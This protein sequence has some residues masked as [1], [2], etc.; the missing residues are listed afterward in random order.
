VAGQGSLLGFLRR[1]PLAAAN[2]NANSEERVSP[3]VTEK[4]ERCEPTSDLIDVEPIASDAVVHD[5]ATDD[6]VADAARLR[7]PVRMADALERIARNV[8]RWSN[9][10]VG[11]EDATVDVPAREHAR[12]K[13]DADARAAL[14]SRAYAYRVRTYA[15]ETKSRVADEDAKDDYNENEHPSSDD[16][17]DER[18]RNARDARDAV[19]ARRD[20]FSRALRDAQTFASGTRTHRVAVASMR[21]DAFASALENTRELGATPLPRARSAALR[22]PAVSCSFDPTGAFLAAASLGGGLC[23]LSS[24]TLRVSDGERFDPRWTRV[25][26]GDRGR[27]P[28]T[29]S[30]VAW[31][32]DGAF[33]ATTSRDSDIVDVVDASVGRTSRTV[34]TRAMRASDSGSGEVRFE[35]ASRGEG[36][37]LLDVCF[38]P[39][40]SGSTFAAAGTRGFVYLWDSRCAG[41]PRAA[42]AAP[43]G[44]RTRVHCVRVGSDA[45]TLFAGTSEGDVHVWDLRGG[46]RG[47]DDG[48]PKS[49]ART[50]AFSVAF[51][52]Q[53][54]FPVLKTVR[55]AD[56]LS[57]VPTMHRGTARSGFGVRAKHISTSGVHWCEQDPCDPRRLGFHLARGWSGVIDLARETPAATHAHC[58]PPPYADGEDGAAPTLA[59]HVSSDAMAHRRTAAWLTIGAGGSKCAA[60]VVGCPGTS[61]VRVLDASP[62]PNARHWVLGVSESTLEA[63]EAK[64][65][66]TVRRWSRTSRAGGS[67]VPD[68][69]E[70]GDGNLE[71]RRYARVR[72]R[73]NRWWPDDV[74]PTSGPAFCVATSRSDPGHFVCGTYEALSWLGPRRVP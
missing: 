59:P 24:A 66:E 18:R 28:R 30:S 58:P 38:I 73:G 1:A 42:L 25:G 63:E 5:D 13:R 22:D 27:F 46:A 53:A 40:N 67:A 20:S 72:G 19:R 8:E 10:F 37:G 14:T 64:E 34:A 41:A 44:V 11:L 57:L 54:S 70:D 2:D 60:L 3:M 69:N 48:V 29:L 61:G 51:R 55:V 21:A 39:G 23:V 15:R 49:R 52:K 43:S 9:L 17:R 45:Q 35:C 16:D 36:L 56:A 68:E 32:G 6:V 62:T 7:P 50:S 26:F 4:S 33:L 47:E 71:D 31:S 74:I 12:A 65:A